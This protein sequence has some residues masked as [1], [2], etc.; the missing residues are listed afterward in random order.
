MGTKTKETKF[1]ETP[2]EIQA[3][4]EVA[5]RAMA[6]RGFRFDMMTLEMDISACHSNGCPLDFEKLLG[7]DKFNFMHDIVGISSNINRTT[8]KL[9]NCF[10]PRCSI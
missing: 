9:K 7:F 10:L 1:A 6:T 2:K 3:I 4:H 5:K 8:G